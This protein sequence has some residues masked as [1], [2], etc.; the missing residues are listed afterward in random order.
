[1]GASKQT[2]RQFAAALA[3]ADKYTAPGWIEYLL[4][5]TLEGKRDRPFKL[6][7]PLAPEELEALRALRDEAKLWFFWE[8][9]RWNPVSVEEWRKHTS[10]VSADDVLQRTIEMNARR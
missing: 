5:E 10:S 7:E 9:E 2:I 4:W 8:A 6:L 3:L 1:M